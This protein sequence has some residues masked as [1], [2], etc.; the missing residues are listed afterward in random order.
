MA[1]K[2][3]WRSHLEVSEEESFPSL[4]WCGWR[5]AQRPQGTLVA[6]VTGVR[7]LCAQGCLVMTCSGQLLA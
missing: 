7:S 2:E 5:K 3:V 1:G 4:I 6:M